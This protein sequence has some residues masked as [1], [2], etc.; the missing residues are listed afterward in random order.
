MQ[1]K[2]TK[3]TRSDKILAFLYE[4]GKGESARIRYEDIV[5][6]LFKKYPQDFQLKGYPEY[7]DSGD[8]IH[9]PLYDFKKKGYL[10][11]A[12]KVFAL[13]DR[14]MEVARQL[15]NVRESKGVSS[16]RFSR[17]TET[18]V[19][20][21][22]GLEGFSLFVEGKTNSLSDNDFYNYLGVTVRTQKNAFV[23]RLQT[24]SDIVKE[25]ESKYS[26]DPICLKIS[27]YHHYLTEKHRDIID[28]FSNN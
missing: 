28:Y 26:K 15:N 19:A 9:K 23:G 13:T 14:G 10:T 24:I 3:L 16:D 5:A 11:A 1:N 6:G 12:N 27:E 18:E 20:R 25:L 21:I 4:Y 7:P 2:N 22:K 17:S 8:L